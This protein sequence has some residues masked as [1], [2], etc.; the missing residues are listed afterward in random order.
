MVAAAAER[1]LA[2]VER[3]LILTALTARGNSITIYTYI[4]G[5]AQPLTKLN[6]EYL[7]I[8]VVTSLALALSVPL[9]RWSVRA[10]V[11][12]LVLALVFFVMV[13]VCVVQLELTAENYASA[14]LGLTIYT[15][16]EKA[17]LDW[18]IRKS[19]LA[20]V[21]VVPALLFLISYLMVW[22]GAGRASPRT[23]DKRSGP[24]T[25]SRRFIRIGWRSVS[26]AVAV[27][28]TAWLLLVP[29]HAD[30]AGRVDLQGLQK[31][32]NLNPSSARAHFGLAFNLE[33]AGRLDEALDSYQRALRLQPDLVE[34]HFGAG[35]VF[36]RKGAFDLAASDYEEVLKYQPGNMAA[37]H[38]L[39]NTFLRRGLFDLAAQSYEEIL[40][41]DPNDASA[42]KNLGETL[43]RL[44]R[45]CD[46]LTHLERS[47]V[48][49][50]RL[51]TD[52]TLQANISTL[53]SI[54]EPK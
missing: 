52:A 22:S 42:H 9:K 33:K 16:R 18:A 30:P 26:V 47:T 44:N 23:I 17:I 10:R 40:R 41:A 24:D 1:V 38:N 25:G 39:G 4:S 31:I 2:L 43:L 11:C 53:R 32:V 37:R 34:A 14:R 49:E 50:P 45:R 35:N 36:F 28:V 27:S 15:A 21:F 8:S 6:C 7:H 3:P 12:G 5:V 54:C 48:L 19:S 51:A 20:L 29:P 46:A 13:A